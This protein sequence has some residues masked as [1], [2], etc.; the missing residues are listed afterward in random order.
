MPF[1]N[2][3]SHRRMPH[4]PNTPKTPTTTQL[5]A[6]ATAA[7]AAQQDQQQADHGFTTLPGRELE[8]GSS[9][10][11]LTAS[12][13]AA[14]AGSSSQKLLQDSHHQSDNTALP[15]SSSSSIST[16]PGGGSRGAIKDSEMAGGLMDQ[17]RHHIGVAS[18]L[19]ALSL[20]SGSAASASTSPSLTTHDSKMI[21]TALYDAFGVLYHPSAHTKHSLSST[22]AALRSGDVTPLMGLSPKASPLLRPQYL[23]TSA[24]ITPLELSEEAS[25][26]GYFGLHL[27]A[28][29]A[30][31]T[32]AAITG[33]LAATGAGGSNLATAGGAGVSSSHQGHGHHHHYH[34]QHHHHHHPHRHT[35]TSSHLSATYTNNED[36]QDELSTGGRGYRS[37]LSRSRRTSVDFTLDPTEHPVLSSLQTL[38]ITHP[39]PPEHYHP[40]L[41]HDLGHDRVPIAADSPAP[42]PASVEHNA[43][44]MKLTLPT[45]SSSTTSTT[46]ST[47]T[48]TTTATATPL[49][50]STEQSHSSS[51]F[52]MD[53][54]DRDSISGFGQQGLV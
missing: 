9:T 10:L 45:T 13:T 46:T 8:N 18:P 5:P 16:L 48:T 41:G 30:A 51:P 17:D 15:A 50:H 40:H 36:H 34:H 19:G 23:G 24:P 42:A 35:H 14:V 54:G 49:Q 44:S 38:S 7:A 28:S 52:P 11:R 6:A 31:S 29:S 37:P 3:T 43:S 4:L 22:A 26:A 33:T 21:K 25:A 20:S 1:P 39:H 2:V 47:T 12:S 53:R 27:P 32:S